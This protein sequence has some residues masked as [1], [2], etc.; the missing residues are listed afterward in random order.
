MRN[1]GA[2]HYSKNPNEH[3]D[4][5]AQAF[6]DCNHLLHPRSDPGWKRVRQA[7]PRSWLR[8]AR[9]GA[10]TEWLANICYAVVLGQNGPHKYCKSRQSQMAMRIKF[11][12]PL[13]AVPGV[14]PYLQAQF[15]GQKGKQVGHDSK[16]KPVILQAKNHELESLGLLGSTVRMASS[17]WQ[18][19][20]E[21]VFSCDPRKNWP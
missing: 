4:W 21:G 12:L 20:R 6:K 14:Y 18:A 2:K 5:R 9:A 10:L 8:G 11:R 7:R 3:K 15:Q 13:E 19:G 16:I 17:V 1:L